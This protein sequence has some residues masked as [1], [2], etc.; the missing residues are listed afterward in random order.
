MKYVHLVSIVMIVARNFFLRHICKNLDYFTQVIKITHIVVYMSGILLILKQS[1]I[2]N[3][4]FEDEIVRHDE[5]EIFSIDEYVEHLYKNAGSIEYELMEEDAKQ[6]E[7][8]Y[9]I[10]HYFN[11]AHA[12]R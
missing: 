6:K 12:Y 1:L 9:F 7:R 5:R 3:Y 2:I 11:K 4:H 10:E 8:E